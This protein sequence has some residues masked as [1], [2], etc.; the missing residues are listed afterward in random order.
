MW[1]EAR[2]RTQAL[3][4]GILYVN[5]NYENP[6]GGSTGVLIIHNAKNNAKLEGFHETTIKGL[7]I[8]DRIEKV[9]EGAKSD[10][11]II[12]SIFTLGSV[13]NVEIHQQSHI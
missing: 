2:L 1:L 8:A 6:P 7:I 3:C 9:T 11:Q 13:G 12:G 4:H 5:R 10:G